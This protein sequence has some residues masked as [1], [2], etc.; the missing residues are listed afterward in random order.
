MIESLFGC[1]R[2][3]PEKNAAE[4]TDAAPSRKNSE[5]IAGRETLSGDALV[6]AM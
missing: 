6:L 5:E 4:Q 2:R 1:D 3:T